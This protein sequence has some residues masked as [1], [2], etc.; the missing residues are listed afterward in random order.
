MMHFIYFI[1]ICQLRLDFFKVVLQQPAVATGSCTDTYLTTTAGTTTA[2]FQ[3]TPPVLCGTLT[4]Q[5]SNYKF[6]TYISQDIEYFFHS[7]VAK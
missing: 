3:N 6:D 2:S 5:H 1:D 4:D 7:I